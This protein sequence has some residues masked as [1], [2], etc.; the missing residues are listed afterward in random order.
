MSSILCYCCSG[1]VERAD[2]T[3]PA[4]VSDRK[5]SQRDDVPDGRE[6]AAGSSTGVHYDYQIFIASEVAEPTY[7]SMC[8]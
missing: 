6:C 3:D 5:R 2:V 8:M 1:S 7:H 4:A